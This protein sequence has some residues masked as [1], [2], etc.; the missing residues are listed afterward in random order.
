MAPKLPTRSY[1]NTIYKLLL[2]KESIK[3]DQK[4]EFLKSIRRELSEG[5]Q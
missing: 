4:K 5:A 3:P 1:I 2:E